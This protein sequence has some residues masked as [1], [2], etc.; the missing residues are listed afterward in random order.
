MEKLQDILILPKNKYLEIVEKE[1]LSIFKNIYSD[2]II[3]NRKFNSLF[4]LG[5]TD[6]ESK[7]NNYYEEVFSEWENFIKLK[8][9]EEKRN[10]YYLME[11]RR[12]CHNHE[13]YAMHKC[14][15]REKGKFIK[16]FV[17]RK[18]RF[19]KI[20]EIKYIICEECKKVF[21]KDLF[22]NYCPK[23][24]ENFLSGYLD[25]NENKELF[26]STYS[27][28]HCDNIINKIILCKLCKEKMYLSI[29]DKILKCLKCNYFIDLNNQN[30]FQWR[31]PK[32]NKY[33]KSNVKIYNESENNIL[34]K[35]VNKALLLK[36]KARPKILKCCNIDIN[37]TTFFH[38]KDCD[39]ILY[40]CN[41]ENYVLDKKL[42]IV[43]A[44]CHAI[45]NST[46]FIWTCPNCEKRTREINNGDEDTG[47]SPSIKFRDKYNNISTIGDKN[48]SNNKIYLKTNVYKKYLSNFLKRK[49]ALSPIDLK[50]IRNNKDF[51]QNEKIIDNLE[52]ENITTYNNN[53]P[54]FNYYM[55]S[56][57]YN[58]KRNSQ[59][60]Q[61]NE[62]ENYNSDSNNNNSIVSIN[63]II[64][65]N[66]REKYIKKKK[67][68]LEERQQNNNN[69]KKINEN[70]IPLPL[71]RSN[72]KRNKNAIMN[73]ILKEQEQK[74]NIEK[75][76]NAERNLLDEKEKVN[77]NFCMDYFSQNIIEKNNNEINVNKPDLNYNL[78]KKRNKPVRLIYINDKKDN[79]I[80]SNNLKKSLDLVETNYK[81]KGA[82]YENNEEELKYKNKK[83]MVYSAERD[84]RISKDS[85]THGSKASYTSS[86]KDSNLLT[87]K[88][89][90]NDNESNN[91]KEK[92]MFYSSSSS[93]YRRKRK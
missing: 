71:P 12:H 18:T 31:C 42:A 37:N 66:S 20:K 61:I 16:I 76:Q 78:Q 40:L 69:E 90:D 59:I 92:D 6:F 3:L 89:M 54:Y 33:F 27:A 62:N 77:E 41:I 32:C 46:N 2:K 43:C 74:N 67:K 70:T 26:L 88:K 11:F 52:Q 47:N 39:G 30:E 10:S 9:D 57:L 65:K 85:T 53:I 83:I 21:F 55:R 28:P 24:K 81:L 64:C 80:K 38:K 93:F 23:C 84:G 5:K 35:I 49:S 14:G 82:D 17:K 58:I 36:I 60:N 63:S 25:P 34:T 73:S 7:Y 56:K 75:K 86:L 45:N 8:N 51:N 91:S 79:N 87:T 29:N 19:R 44:K 1:V 50:Y 13:G 72:Y 4:I 68:L 22:V 15:Y 48:N